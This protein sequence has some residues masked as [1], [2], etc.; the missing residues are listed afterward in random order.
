MKHY[1]Y[2]KP[3]NDKLLNFISTRSQLFCSSPSYMSGSIMV[4]NNI[5]LTR[6]YH[7]VLDTTET[8]S[9]NGQDLHLATTLDQCMHPDT[10][11]RYPERSTVNFPAYYPPARPTHH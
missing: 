2:V 6:R 1:G 5:L 3:L 10:R 8:N 9:T 11:H 7:Y 4:I